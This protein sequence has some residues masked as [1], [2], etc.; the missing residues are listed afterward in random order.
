MAKSEDPDVYL[1]EL[2]ELYQLAEKIFLLN[3]NLIN[4]IEDC[5]KTYTLTEVS[6]MTRRVSVTFGSY[7]YLEVHDFIKN[8]Q[9]IDA[10]DIDHFALMSA[11]LVMHA[12][13]KGFDIAQICHVMNRLRLH[14]TSNDDLFKVICVPRFKLLGIGIHKVINTRHDNEIYLYPLNTDPREFLWA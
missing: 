2:Q 3:I 9:S 10:D 12:I 1:K 13:N 14:K 6:K 8:S 4:Y 11:F 5:L 7:N